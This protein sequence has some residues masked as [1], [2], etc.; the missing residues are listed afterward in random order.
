ML[1]AETGEGRYSIMIYDAA[2]KQVSDNVPSLMYR[3]PTKPILFHFTLEFP[4][5]NSVTDWLIRY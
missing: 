5:Y 2:N 4:L 3:W 1:K